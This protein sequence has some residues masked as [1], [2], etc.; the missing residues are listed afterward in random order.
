[1]NIPMM[2]RARPHSAANRGVGSPQRFPRQRVTAF[3]A[4]LKALRPQF[5]VRGVEP[6]ASTI[7]ARLGEIVQAAEIP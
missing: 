7:T 6:D 4:S 3:A 2:I 5:D 1:M